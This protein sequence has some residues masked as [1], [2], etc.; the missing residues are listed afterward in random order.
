MKDN[1][2]YSE[3]QIEIFEGLIQLI[4]EGAN[5]YYIKV[6]DIAK[7]SN[8]GKGTIYDHF[9]SKEEAISKAIIY[10]ITNEANIALDRIRNKDNFKDRYYELLQTMVDGFETNLCTIKMLMSSGGLREFYEYL[11]DDKYD[12][13]NLISIFIKEV[14]ELLDMGYR[15]GIIKKTESRYYELMAI[16]GTISSFSQYISRRNFFKNTT[17][18]EAMDTSY[19]ILTKSLN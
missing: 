10:N 3:K 9:Q 1:I 2:Q 7:A 16:K 12:L 15:E 17:L 19:K 8:V 4:R 5:P 18:D 13:S 14:E 11:V 6:A